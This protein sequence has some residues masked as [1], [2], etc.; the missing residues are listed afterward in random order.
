MHKNERHWLA[1]SLFNIVFICIF[2]FSHASRNLL[3]NVHKNDKVYKNIFIENKR[4]GSCNILLIY[5]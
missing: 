5:K 1:K 4:N 3:G 2:F